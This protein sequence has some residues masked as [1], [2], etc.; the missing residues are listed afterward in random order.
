M[1]KVRV[2]FAFRVPGGAGGRTVPYHV[3]DQRDLHPAVFIFRV[4]NESDASGGIIKCL[5]HA[6]GL[7]AHSVYSPVGVFDVTCAV[8]ADSE[9][10]LGSHSSSACTGVRSSSAF[11]WA[12]GGWEC[13]GP[14]Y[15][16]VS[17]HLLTR[18]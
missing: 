1:R 17:R 6:C 7:S 14:Q 13:L 2:Y 4:P 3:L 15:P 18:V 8:L 10:G 16:L 9:L 5:Y 11:W 12:G